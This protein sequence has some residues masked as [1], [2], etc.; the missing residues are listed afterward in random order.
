MPVRT[1]LVALLLALLGLAFS[2]A[3]AAEDP[4]GPPSATLRLE[5]TSVAAGGDPKV[6]PLKNQVGVSTLAA[7]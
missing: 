7:S 4:L 2:A 5:S 3:L 1:A 6:A